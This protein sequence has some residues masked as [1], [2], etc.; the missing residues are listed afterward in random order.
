MQEEQQLSET[1]PKRRLSVS[2]TDDSKTKK[3]K[4]ETTPDVSEDESASESEEDLNSMDG[5]CRDNN[6]MICYRT[7]RL[8]RDHMIPVNFHKVRLGP[9]WTIMNYLPELLIPYHSM[10]PFMITERQKNITYHISSFD[11][12]ISVYHS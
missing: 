10:M 5:M 2:H 1:K 6:C 12:H 11:T 4:A 7:E 8:E 3:R 9:G